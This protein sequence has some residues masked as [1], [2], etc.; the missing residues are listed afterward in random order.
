ML[1]DTFN[2]GMTPQ[3]KSLITS[4]GM[5]TEIIH[6]LQSYS[7]N[8]DNLKHCFDILTESDDLCAEAKKELNE[9]YSQ[10][11][12]ICRVAIAYY[13]FDPSRRDQFSF[14]KVMIKLEQLHIPV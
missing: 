13:Q 9:V 4:K 3:L 10:I 7:D 2:K 1:L 5:K 11:K 12:D 8:L 6:R 14:Y